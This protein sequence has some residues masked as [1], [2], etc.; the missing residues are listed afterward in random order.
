MPTSSFG[1]NDLRVVQ[2][3]QQPCDTGLPAAGDLAR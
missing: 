3:D 2:G 1:L